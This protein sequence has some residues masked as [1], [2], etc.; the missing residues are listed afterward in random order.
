MKKFWRIFHVVIDV[1]IVAALIGAI[2]YVAYKVGQ[3]NGFINID[4]LLRHGF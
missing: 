2:V 1:L 4:N 3:A